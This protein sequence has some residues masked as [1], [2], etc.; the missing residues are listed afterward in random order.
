MVIVEAGN[1]ARTADGR[2]LC[3]ILISATKDEI[4]AIPFNPYGATVELVKVEKKAEPKKTEH[5]KV[6]R[7]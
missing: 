4:A 5:K 7:K 3:G 1:V 2:A 6:G